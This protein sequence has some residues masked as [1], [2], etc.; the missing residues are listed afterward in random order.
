MSKRV[1]RSPKLHWRDS[2]LLHAVLQIPDQGSLLSQPWVGASWESF[3]VEQILGL[4]T[5]LGTAHTGYHFRAGERNEIDLVLEVDGEVWAIEYKLTTSPSPHDLARLD[6][7]AE[8]INAN[9]RFLVSQTP[10][11]SGDDGRASHNLGSFSSWL[12]ERFGRK[13]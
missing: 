9:R 6:R 11:S 4:L 1:T 8:L 12:R 7:S 2:G 13:P 10:V 5:A 3:V